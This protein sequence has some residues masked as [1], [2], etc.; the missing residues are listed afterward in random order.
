[1]SHR[2]GEERVHTYAQ[3]ERMADIF[4]HKVP[5]LVIIIP[6]TKQRAL[7][8]HTATTYR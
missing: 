3:E 8:T 7:E 5:E 6:C 4:V 1:M 2:V